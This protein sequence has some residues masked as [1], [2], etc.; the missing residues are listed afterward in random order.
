MNMELFSTT[1]SDNPLLAEAA[2]TLGRAARRDIAVTRSTIHDRQ[3]HVDQGNQTGARA[4]EAHDEY[5]AIAARRRSALTRPRW[6]RGWLHSVAKLLL[7]LAEVGAGTA[8]LYVAG[9]PW[10]LAV[11]TFTGVAVATV[12]A[13]SIIG[14]QVRRR[15][16]GEP[17]GLI[18]LA[19]V[20]IVLAT[21]MLGLYRYLT[22]GP[23]FGI[24]AFVTAM[25][26]LG[27][28]FL[29]YLW[30]DRVADEVERA[31]DCHRGLDRMA[32]AEH[33]HKTVRRFEQA[34]ATIRMAAADGLHI[35]Y[36]R[37]QAPRSTFDPVQPA[38]AIGADGVRP[39][40]RA[41]AD[42][43]LIL[44]VGPEILQ[45]TPKVAVEVQP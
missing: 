41:M 36:S 6:L 39:P 30:H 42:E 5:L 44:L 19:A 11:L 28:A 40:D 25:V 34:E 18:P 43:L 31:R 21:L 4:R 2:A 22:L 16:Q 33:G 29:S 26:A 24:L 1:R 45:L 38:P 3:Y 13:G 17:G 15:E 27:S 37:S 14:I 12:L 32:R 23:V 10:P 35:A 7:L 20:A 9:D 8:A